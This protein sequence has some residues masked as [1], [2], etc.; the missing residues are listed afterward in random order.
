[1]PGIHGV[2][3]QVELDRAA[4]WPQ[5]SDGGGGGRRY[6]RERA[7]EEYREARSIM[8]YVVSTAGAAC[9]PGSCA[10]GFPQI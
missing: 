4:C 10:Q 6:F 9:Q 8:D 2:C 5:P 3:R 7:G 1:M